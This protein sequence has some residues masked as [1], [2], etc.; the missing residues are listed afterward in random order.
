MGITSSLVTALSGLSTAQSQIDVVGNN[1][2][3]VNTVGFKSS[4]LDFKTQFLQNFSFGSAPN[5]TL[6]GTNPLQIGLGA[7]TGSITR[8]FSDG[9]L[10]VTGVPTNL[11]IQ[12]QGMFVLQ[13]GAQQVY[14]RD[15][16]F[17]LNG[18]NQLVSGTGQLVQGYTVDS[19]FNIIP[20]N[21]TGITIPLG[22]QTVAQATTNATMT[23]NLNSGGDLPTTVSDITGPKFYLSDG[24]GGVDA[25]NPPTG[26]TLLTD[27][28][29]SS[30][31]PIFQV[32]DT[33]NLTASKGNR[34]IP[35]QNYT[36]TAGS[37][38]ADLQSYMTGGLGINTSAGANGPVATT[39][40]T[41]LVPTG[42][43]AA[44][45][46]SGNPGT[47]NDITLNNSSLSITRGA[48]TLSPF[49]WSKN[50]AADGES[51]YTAIRAYD[52][53]GTPI[54]VNVVATMTSETSTGSTW[55]YYADSPDSTPSAAGIPA[56]TAGMGTLSFD[57]SGH[58]T[59][60][61][62]GTVSID[63]SQTG[64]VPALVFNLDF[65]NTTAL[66]GFTSTMA[67]TRQDGSAQGTLT[68][69]SIGADGVIVGSFTNGLSRTVGQVALASFR[70]EQGLIDLGNNTWGAGPNSG[71]AI[72][73]APAEFGAGKI[74]AGSLEL[75]NVDLSQ[76]FVRLIAASTAFS[77][78]SRVISSSNSL[79]Q[80]LLSAAR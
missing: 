67:S 44:L 66:S 45:D 56:T 3:N 75:S 23:G 31:T 1:I 33:L 37:T 50:A 70:N 4:R 24:L 39:P 25:V 65:S 7:S 62:T 79:L 73:S 57:T 32:G 41:T 42:N 80:D 52:S 35:A 74:V 54:T 2:A 16:S 12:G 20:G 10:Q 71:T 46:I 61:T 72:I 76:E 47:A 40:G 29:D 43:F 6:G 60:N 30:G 48:T 38:L 68:S 77:A 17:Q 27:V 64:A 13:D 26:A 58:L 11:A 8:D 28:T 49:T 59:G 34:T 15:G 69:F 55:T 53:L 18:L 36:I 63:R 5:G 51:V 19:G 22:A 9:S 21:L 14:T 78:S